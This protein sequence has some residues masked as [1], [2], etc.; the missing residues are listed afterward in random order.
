MQAKAAHRSLGDGGPQRP[1]N[2]LWLASYAYIHPQV[3]QRGHV[4]G[5]ESGRPLL[6]I[7]LAC[8]IKMLMEKTRVAHQGHGINTQQRRHP[9]QTA[10]RAHVCPRTRDDLR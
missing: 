3:I 9:R 1:A 8:E 4:N 7:N 5:G 6:E 10:T 2:E